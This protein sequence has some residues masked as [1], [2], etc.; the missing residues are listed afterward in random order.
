MKFP[1]V[2]M[3]GRY[4]AA[5]LIVG[6]CCLL[7]LDQGGVHSQLLRRP[8]ENGAN[9]ETLD[10]F[11]LVPQ[12]FSPQSPQR[13]VNDFLL[14][15]QWGWQV[16][17]PAG[18]AA[19]TKQNFPDSFDDKRCLNECFRDCVGTKE[20]QAA[21]LQTT[22]RDGPDGCFMCNLAQR[23]RNRI[24]G[25]IN[26]FTAT[27]TG[28]VCFHNCSYPDMDY[29]FSLVPKGLAGL[30]RWNAPSKPDNDEVPKAFHIEFDS[31]ETVNRFKSPI[32]SEFGSYASP[33]VAKDVGV[34]GKNNS[35]NFDAA[36]KMIEQKRAVVIGL[37]GL[38]SVHD[39]YSEL[40]PV[41]AMAVE[42]NPDPNDNT[43]IVFARNTGGEGACSICDHPLECP[44]AGGQPAPVS[45]L[46]GCPQ[47][48]SIVTKL[49]LLI[50]PPEGVTGVPEVALMPKTQF[51]RNT[52]ACPEVSY[53]VHPE[54][55]YTED[56]Q[57]VLLTFNLDTCGE[58]ADCI[59]LVEGE[60]HLRW[61]VPKAA[62]L[63]SVEASR[64][65]SFDACIATKK[66]LE[67]ENDT[68]DR[69]T[70]AQAAKLLNTLAQ[71]RA[72]FTAQMSRCPSPAEATIPR[73]QPVA[74]ICAAPSAPLA[75]VSTSEGGARTSERMRRL[76]E[77]IE[78]ILKSKSK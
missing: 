75:A 45:A 78:K 57:G 19:P 70:S 58:N 46:S 39:V 74:G 53:Y 17:H 20:Q 51:Y 54:Q 18:A 3:S 16:S 11:R 68:F 5:A 49:S 29:T 28:T 44:R 21:E 64:S 61:N 55:K 63:A 32:W 66:L 38:D 2:R 71:E 41:Y 8:C 40:H 60:V 10:D 69:P 27:Y 65:R 52:S 22:S 15:P 76:R 43:W 12:Q 73:G 48:S 50:P 62:A 13:D 56:N 4:F 77:R 42:I 37:F 25:H 47:A 14:N 6:L 33:C 34:P 36:Q 7:C 31:R 35:C 72:E 67:T 26:W 24:P 23:R 30:T 59:P 9:P 1:K